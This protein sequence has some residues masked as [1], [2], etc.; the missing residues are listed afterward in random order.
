M[1]CQEGEALGIGLAGRGGTQLRPWEGGWGQR[2][3]GVKRVRELGSGRDGAVPIVGKKTCVERVG[4]Q[5]KG[6][7]EAVQ[8]G[9]E[10]VCEGATGWACRT[11]N[12]W[13]WDDGS[14]AVPE[15]HALPTRG[16]PTCRTVDVDGSGGGVVLVG[17]PR[18]RLGVEGSGG[19]RAW[20]EHLATFIPSPVFRV[21][22]SAPGCT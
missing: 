12:L 15:I 3:A 21:L 18:D 16:A 14:G 11:S 20:A 4:L 5:G 9:R 13:T 8:A 1:A 22:T 7:K 17:Q 19:A 2:M 6:R 10:L